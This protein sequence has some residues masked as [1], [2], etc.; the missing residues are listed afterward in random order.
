VP[1]RPTCSCLQ[2]G[3]NHLADLSHDEFKA[4]Y[5]G[6]RADLRPER[7]ASQLLGAA[8][9]R[10][11][12]A[13]PPEQ[14][15]WVKAGAVTG[16]KNQQQVRSLDVHAFSAEPTREATCAVLCLLCTGKQLLSSTV[17]ALSCSA[18]PAGR[19]PRLAALKVT[20]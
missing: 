19:S 4:H 12:N 5:L 8:P 15:D 13:S 3:L 11:E 10:Y 6:Y 17:C 9:F 20:S 18:D 14:V 16:V 1:H 2:L 7:N